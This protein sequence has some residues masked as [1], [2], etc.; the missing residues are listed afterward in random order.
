[1]ALLKRLVQRPRDLENRTSIVQSPGM[2]SS[3]RIIQHNHFGTELLCRCYR[4]GT[5]DPPNGKT[6]RYPTFPHWKLECGNWECMSKHQIGTM[7]YVVFQNPATVEPL[8]CIPLYFSLPT[9]QRQCIFDPAH[10]S[11]FPAGSKGGHR[12]QYRK[13][14]LDNRRSLRVF[15]NP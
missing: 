14:V 10:A 6:G 7:I 1:M 9:Q 12:N 4:D 13:D 5:S 3:S 8:A 11:R 2:R 15:D